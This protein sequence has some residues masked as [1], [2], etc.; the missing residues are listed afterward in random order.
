MSF[1][2][3][4]HYTVA[5]LSSGICLFFCFR[6]YKRYRA[7]FLF[8]YQNFLV[9]V[10]ITSFI[11]SIGIPLA[12]NILSTENINPRVIAGIIFFPLLIPLIS[13][14]LYFFI[15]FSSTW[16]EDTIPRWFFPGYFAFWLFQLFLHG[17]LILCVPD[18]KN[19][20]LREFAAWLTD[21]TG[22]V[23]QYA[24]LLYMIWRSRHIG[25]KHRAQGIR[26]FALIYF[27]EFL[28][29]DIITSKHLA[30]WIGYP[31]SFFINMLNFLIHIP[32]LFYLI[33]FAKSYFQEPHHLSA[34]SPVLLD[35]FLEYSITKRE[36]EIIKLLMTGK[37]NREIEEKLFISLGTVKNHLYS[38]YQKAGVQNRFQLTSLISKLNNTK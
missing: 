20:S 26:T 16:L 15:R 7:N 13:I 38:I 5:I 33:H 34:D 37:S 27:S 9:L 2:V 11:N 32:P 17:Y 3:T 31:R 35:F 14:T 12:T 28:I 6:L 4:A 18:L 22:I 23:I 36:Q 29:L 10:Y 24:V 19:S 30:A 21:T 8:F 1:E 25:D